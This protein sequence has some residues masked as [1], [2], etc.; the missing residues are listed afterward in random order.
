H[1]T[2]AVPFAAALSLIGPFARQLASDD[3][4]LDDP[5]E[6]ERECEEKRQFD[7]QF[8]GQRA[9]P[10]EWWR[11]HPFPKA[12]EDHDEIR[13]HGVTSVWGAVATCRKGL[14][15]S[16]PRSELARWLPTTGLPS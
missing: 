6:E 4:V 8:E 7:L 15:R 14:P 13:A 1:A 2:N 16:G 10:T 12:L 3:G 5:P 11:E 9:Q